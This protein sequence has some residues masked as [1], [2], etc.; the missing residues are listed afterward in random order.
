[1]KYFEDIAVG[2]RTV[3]GRH[4]FT[5]DEIKTFAARFDPLSSARCIL[6]PLA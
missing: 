4:T 2:E 6:E 1:M 5:A 3:L